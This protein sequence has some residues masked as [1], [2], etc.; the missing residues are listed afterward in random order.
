MAIY[1]CRAWPLRVVIG[2]GCGKGHGGST[3][4][5]SVGKQRLEFLVEDTGHFQNFKTRYLG[6]LTLTISGKH[7]LVVGGVKKAK[8]A[9]MGVRE[10]RLVL[11]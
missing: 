3:A 2:Q 4:Y 8:G 6:T 7:T 10:I 5:L 11:E 9:V 1:Y